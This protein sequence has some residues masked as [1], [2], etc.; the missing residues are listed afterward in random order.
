MH[1]TQRPRIHQ[2]AYLVI[3]HDD[4]EK[5]TP[6][7]EAYLDRLSREGKFANGC[8]QVVDLPKFPAEPKPK[9]KAECEPI[10]T[11]ELV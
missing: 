10:F 5:L 3:L 8:F 1:K 7:Q 9:S 2:P 4:G 6:E 11:V